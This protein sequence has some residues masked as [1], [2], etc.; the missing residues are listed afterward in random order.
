MQPVTGAAI[1]EQLAST[2]CSGVEGE[3]EETDRKSLPPSA[4][5]VQREVAPQG[6]HG[7]D[8]VGAGSQLGSILARIAGHCER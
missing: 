2:A 1:S 5:A 4:A 7:A 3:V 8:S 6:R